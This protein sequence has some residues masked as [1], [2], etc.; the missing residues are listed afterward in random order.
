LAI[1]IFFMIWDIVWW[2]S[3]ISLKFFLLIYSWWGW[4][5]LLISCSNRIIVNNYF[6]TPMFIFLGR[7]CYITVILCPCKLFIFLL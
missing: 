6:N 2:F 7:R 4:P 5:L 1:I 3:A